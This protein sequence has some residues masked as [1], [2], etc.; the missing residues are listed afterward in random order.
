[1]ESGPGARRTWMIWISQTTQPAWRCGT[2]WVTELHQGGRPVL[3][4]RNWVAAEARWR[5]RAGPAASAVGRGGWGVGR[6]GGGGGGGGGRGGRRG[7]GGGGRGIVGCL[8]LRRM[9]NARGG[10]N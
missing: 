5:C 4:R 6:G 9:G 3:A 8:R 1:M 10:R 2:S 7:G